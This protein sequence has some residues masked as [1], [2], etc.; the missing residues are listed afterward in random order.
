[1]S[2]HGKRPPGLVDRGRER[3]SH[4]INTKFWNNK[5]EGLLITQ[6]VF[7]IEILLH[8]F[9][10]LN[11]YVFK[12][13]FSVPSRAWWMIRTRLYYVTQVVETLIGPHFAGQRTVDDK[14]VKEILYLMGEL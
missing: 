12:T 1:M 4:Q 13:Q 3:E 6:R 11:K 5:R 8:H 7:Y 10:R 2:I 9:G 14:L